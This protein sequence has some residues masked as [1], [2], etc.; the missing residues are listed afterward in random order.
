MAIEQAL[1]KIFIDIL[2]LSPELVKKANMENTENWDSFSHITLI[3]EIEQN[4][5][6]G[7][8]GAEKIV[9]LTSF[10]KCLAY[11]YDAKVS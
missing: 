3:M 1:T 11:I 4:C 6:D 10:E 5:V 9:E 2:N 7:Q 8:I